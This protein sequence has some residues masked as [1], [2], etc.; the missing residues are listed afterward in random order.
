MNVGAQTAAFRLCAYQRDAA[1]RGG[2]VCAG[3]RDRIDDRNDRHALNFEA[4]ARVEPCY[5]TSNDRRLE[6]A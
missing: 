1:R 4:G 3:A 2:R 6:D 5:S